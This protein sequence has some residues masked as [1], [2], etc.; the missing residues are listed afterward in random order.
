MVSSAIAP[1]RSERGRADCVS[2]TQSDA[3]IANKVGIHET[4]SHRSLVPTSPASASPIQ[5]A[6]HAACASK[7]SV[8][9]AWG[10]SA[11]REQ[12]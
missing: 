3:V 5:H 7:P 12:R 1:M 11:R 9:R 10:R 8:D 6:T 2:A 4:P